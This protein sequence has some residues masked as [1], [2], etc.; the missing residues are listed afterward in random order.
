M[1]WYV[2]IMAK[3]FSVVSHCLPRGGDPIKFDVCS[4]YI[5]TRMFAQRAIT[6]LSTPQ[7]PL[8][9]DHLHILNYFTYW[10]IQIYINNEEYIRN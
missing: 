6:Q 3:I 4:G 7:S 10:K 1:T 5:W 8:I 9:D 2:V